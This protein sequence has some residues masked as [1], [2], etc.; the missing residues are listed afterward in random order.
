MSP[1]LILVTDTPDTV[2]KPLI[3]SSLKADTFQPL[4][5][6]GMAP[7]PSYTVQPSYTSPPTVYNYINPLTGER[8]VSLLPPSHPEMICLQSGTHI[9]HTHYGLLGE[10][11]GCIFA[12]RSQTNTPSQV[13][14]QPSSGSL[15]V[16]VCVSLTN[17]SDANAA[18]LSLRTESVVESKA[19]TWFMI[20]SPSLPYFRY[21]EP[22]L[23]YSFHHSF[24]VV[25]RPSRYHVAILFIYFITS[26]WSPLSQGAISFSRLMLR[27][28]T[29]SF[30]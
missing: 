28:C 13:F 8:V 3:P 30:N 5:P 16:S 7:G 21:I 9:P 23:C 19:D 26:V 17:G 14:L 6:Q 20:P 11:V 18:V 2:P 22:T 29:Y 4:I 15:L 10:F 12:S 25:L 24:V 1:F 27:L